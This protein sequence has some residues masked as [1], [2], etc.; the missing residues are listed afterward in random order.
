MGRPKGS[1][2]KTTIEGEREATLTGDTTV[3]EWDGSEDEAEETVAVV[4]SDVGSQPITNDRL[5][6]VLEKIVDSSPVKKVPFSKFKTRSP[7]NPT[8]ARRK[9]DCRFYQNGYPVNIDKLTP[10]EVPLFNEL[11]GLL[12]PGDIVKAKN[13]LSWT[14]VQKGG[15]M[16]VHLIYKNKSQDERMALKSEFRNLT[17]MLTEGVAAAQELV[18]S[19]IP[20]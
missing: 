11:A 19:R 3:M 2:N 17:D 1:K 14:K 4:A 16:D 8:G 18:A 7:F 6:E 13:L 9:L 5:A 10:K 20:R 12:K 15:N